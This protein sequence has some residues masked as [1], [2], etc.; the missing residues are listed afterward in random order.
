[1][2]NIIKLDTAYTTAPAST[3]KTFGLSSDGKDPIQEALDILE[4]DRNVSN[5]E[6]IDSLIALLRNIQSLM[7][8]LQENH[9]SKSSIEADIQSKLVTVNKQL[10]EINKQEFE[11]YLRK[12][13]ESKKSNFIKDLFGAILPFL[14]LVFPPLLTLYPMGP[15]SL[16]LNPNSPFGMGVAGKAIEDKWGK[17]A[18]M[19]LIIGVEVAMVITTTLLTCGGASLTRAFFNKFA[20]EACKDVLIYAVGKAVTSEEFLKLAT[21]GIIKL[22]EKIKGKELSASEKATIQAVVSLTVQLALLYAV[23]KV[24]ASNANDP[25]KGPSILDSMTA[26]LKL[27]KAMIPIMFSL[28]AAQAGLQMWSGITTIEIAKIKQTLQE[29]TAQM[30]QFEG[31]SETQKVQVRNSVKEMQDRLGL[32]DPTKLELE[33]VVKFGS[34][35]AKVL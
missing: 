11:E 35:A 20:K 7:V 18:A 6:M 19:G 25:L 17:D 28:E 14:A 23:F 5:K 1:M 3:I 34:K 16:L 10:M 22:G 2:T 30:K 26:S 8:T 9:A 15:M 27:Q 13:E 12:V 32:I 31:V 21:D 29:I 33:S 24:K 4:A